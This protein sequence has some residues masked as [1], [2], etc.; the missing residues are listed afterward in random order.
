MNLV[1]N[2]L[3]D[4]RY[5]LLRLLGSGGFSEVWLVEDTKVNNQQKALKVYAP[6]KGLDDD[7]VELFSREFELV[8]NLN[9][10]HLLRPSHF[11]VFERSP[12]LVLPF[13]E[14]GSAFKL[15]GKI[16][17]E[18]AWRFMRDVA[19]GLAY[20]HAQR[21]PVIHQDIKPDNVL[22]DH[23]GN[24]LITDFG[25]S[26]RARST[27]RKSMGDI[28]SGGTLAYMAPERFGKDTS[29]SLAS[30]VWALGAT[31]F[32]LL[33]G[34]APFGE[35]GGLVLKSG[36]DIPDIA[37][38]YSQ[39]LKDIVYKMLSAEADNRPTAAQTVEWTVAHF[40]GETLP[41][42]TKPE[43]KIVE[44]IKD[45]KEEQIEAQPPKISTFQSGIIKTWLIILFAVFS[46]L[47]LSF[48]GGL[49]T[50]SDRASTLDMAL[51]APLATIT[52]VSVFLLLKKMRIGFWG[53]LSTIPIS[54]AAGL[55][56][57]SS[58]AT[59]FT[60]FAVIISAVTFGVLQIGKYWKTLE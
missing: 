11:D 26:S 38:D 6:G 22:I 5:R 52:S 50:G 60:I 58:L 24:Y 34:D 43:E 37:D 39:E 29:P 25:I 36:A 51:F 16:G 33:C 15:I 28:K 42:P 30:D 46:L 12:Y 7:G 57:S 41:I 10:A 1:E 17:E 13:C 55:I 59:G 20:L 23:E 18:E 19:S 9:H 35:H 47:A 32:E 40:N 4:N 44:K 45:E 21:E 27:L 53:L 8:Y 49:L 54:L 56:F 14:R 48:W 3:F 31:M 2:N